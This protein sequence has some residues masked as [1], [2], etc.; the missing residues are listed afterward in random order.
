[1]ALAGS[2]RLTKALIHLAELQCPAMQDGAPIKM[3]LSQTELG[4]MTGLTRESVNKFLASLHDDG[5]I[6]LSGGAVTLLDC[7]ALNNLLHDQD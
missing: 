2:A 5:L 4:G 7:V 1:V 6:S 3:Y